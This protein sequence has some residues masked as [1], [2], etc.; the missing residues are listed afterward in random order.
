MHI[1]ESQKPLTVSACRGINVQFLGKAPKPSPKWLYRSA[2][3][4]AGSQWPGAAC[5]GQ[6]GVP[7]AFLR[8]CRGGR[9]GSLSFPR[10]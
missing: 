6:A 8:V 9:C 7:L 3:S 4:A 2:F 1:T 5:R 10:G